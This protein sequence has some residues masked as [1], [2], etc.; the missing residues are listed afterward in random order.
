MSEPHVIVVFGA[1]G[2]LA[3]RKLLPGI[4]HLLNCGL[5]DDLR[6]IGSSTHEYDG[7]ENF[8]RVRPSPRPR[9]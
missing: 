9:K 8:P 7:G 3:K 4:M 6:L 5:V 2:D 1:T